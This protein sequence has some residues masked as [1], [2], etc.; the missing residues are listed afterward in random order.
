LKRSVRAIVLLVVVGVAAA[1]LAAAASAKGPGVVTI[2]L[3]EKDKTFHF[4]DN[5]P[6]GGENQP[7]SQGDQFVFTSE[8]LTRSGKHAGMLRATCTVTSG[9]RDGAITCFGTYGLKGGQLAAIT[10]I[11]G[12]AKADRIAIVGGTGVYAG[13][14][15]EVISVS[16]GDNSPFSDAT[17]RLLRS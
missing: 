8:L 11:V 4:V 16:R 15:G 17:I 7:P 2:H 1:V 14:R 13:A 3:V 6:L 12:E 10:T 9:G 5:P